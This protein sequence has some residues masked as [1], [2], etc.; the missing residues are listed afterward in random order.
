MQA[1]LGLHAQ[2]PGSVLRVVNPNLPDWLGV[3]RVRN[4][5]VG[6]GVVSLTFTRRGRDTDV[7]V[8]GV[9]GHGKVAVTRRWPGI[10]HSD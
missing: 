5:R 7:N 10:P 6:D 4:L 9:E 8:D 1:L 2:F 3:A